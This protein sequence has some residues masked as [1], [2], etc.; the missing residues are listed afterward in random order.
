MPLVKGSKRPAGGADPGPQRA[1]LDSPDADSRWMAARGLS[2]DADAVPALASALARE[3]VP[4]VREAIMTALMRIGNAASVEA[5]LP[6]LRSQE[7]GVRGDAIEALQALPHAIAPFMGPL[8]SD[9]D[10]DVR[11]LATELARNMKAAEATRLLSEL[12]ERE[13]HANVCA[14]AIDVLTEVGTP[15]ALAALEKCAT[16]FAATPFLPFAISVAIA[17]ISGAEG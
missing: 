13:Q 17:R 15:Q 2:G 6:Y 9:S 1:A 11:L 3:T 8:L 16:R 5:I 14:A 7:A 10:S 4:R 12:I